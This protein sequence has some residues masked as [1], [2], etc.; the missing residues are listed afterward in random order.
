[1]CGKQTKLTMRIARFEKQMN[2]IAKKDPAE[3]ML[4]T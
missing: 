4:Q 2:S 3:F 1:M